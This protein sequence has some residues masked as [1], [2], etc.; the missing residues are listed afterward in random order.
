MGILCAVFAIESNSRMMKIR[1]KMAWGAALAALLGVNA[2]G[3]PCE[4]T[5]CLNG[6]ACL[7]GSCICPEG[8]TGEYCEELEE[9]DVDTNDPCYG[10]ICLNGGECVNGDCDCPP[11][12]VGPDCGDFDTGV[13]VRINSMVLS[14]YSLTTG[15]ASWDESWT[16]VSGPDIYVEV[17]QSNGTDISTGY[18][19]NTT[20]G[21][22]T[23]SASPLPLT[24]YNPNQTL[25]FAVWDLDDIDGTDFASSDDLMYFKSINLWSQYITSSNAPY[26]TVVTVQFP[27]SSCQLKLYLS[28]IW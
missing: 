14:N 15:G 9:P 12:F 18:Y 26:P 10:I 8:W 7:D 4:D 23:F 11:G 25:S 20:G 13:D 22:L 21:N 24:I 5:V 3:D 19:E 28:Y 2:C 16:G 27:A 1:N 6:G 17:L